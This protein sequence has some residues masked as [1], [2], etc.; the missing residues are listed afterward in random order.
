MADQ[1]LGKDECLD[2]CD[3]GVYEQGDG[4]AAEEI[5]DEGL[6]PLQRITKY[7]WAEEVYN[8]KYVATVLLEIIQMAPAEPL[9]TDLPQIMDI[10]GK[11]VH[12]AEVVV[13]IDALEHIPSLAGMA[14][15]CAQKV[16]ALANITSEYLLSMVVNNLGDNDNQVRKHAQRALFTLLEQG[17]VSK[18]QAEI[19][20]CPTILALTRKESMVTDGVTLMAKVVP[21][22]GRDVTERVF[23]DRFVELCAAMKFYV[24]KICASHVGDFCAIISRPLFEKVLFIAYAKL[25]NDEAWGV[26]KACADVAM[27][28]SCACS[29][30]LRKMV[31]APAFA[32]LLRDKCRWV[33]ISAFQTLGPFISTFAEPTI[34]SLAYN[35]M[36]ELVLV[37][38]GSEFKINNSSCTP[39]DEVKNLFYLCLDDLD[40]DSYD[41]GF[42]RK[43][44]EEGEQPL[45]PEELPQLEAPPPLDEQSNAQKTPPPPEEQLPAPK[46]LSPPLKDDRKTDPNNAWV[47]DVILKGLDDFMLTEDFD[48]D[49]MILRSNKST[50]DNKKQCDNL[51]SEISTISN[52]AS[53]DQLENVDLS[54]SEQAT[55]SSSG[56]EADRADS[57]GACAAATPEGNNDEDGLELYNS[58]NYWYVPPDMPLDPNIVAGIEIEKTASDTTDLPSAQENTDAFCKT[59]TDFE[60]NN[61]NETVVVAAAADAT[62]KADSPSDVLLDGESAEITELKEP[63]QKIV[64]QLLIDHFISMADPSI[65]Q[66]IDDNIAYHCAY[67]LPAV[68]L[69]LG[70]VNSHL[71][72]ETVGTLAANMQYKVR[73]TLASSLHELAIIWGS[74]IASNDLA[75]IFNEFIKDLDEVRI[76]VLKNLAQFLRLINPTKRSMYL[77]RLSFFLQNNQKL[78]WRYRHE[79]AEQLLKSVTMFTPSEASKHISHIAQRLL[80]DK[81]AAVR[82]MALKLVAQLLQHIN[83]EPGLSSRML[84][85]FAETFAHSKKWKLRQTFVFLSWELLVGKALPI[86]QFASDVMPHL[87]DLSWDPVANVRLVVAQTVVTHM[88][89]NEYFRDPENQ[90][91]DLLESVLRRLQTDE[92]IDVRQAAVV[93]ACQKYAY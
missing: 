48:N 54:R 73:H 56:D 38:Y 29:P 21:L 60:T 45:P 36:G 8:R 86:E 2:D 47:M 20:V 9:S 15:K 32:R 53:G 4:P 85:K 66:D 37:C 88:I 3:E 12:D 27:S 7:A 17:L 50:D 1:S 43:R 33:R 49:E 79:L 11:L 58:H 87:L 65:A 26:R 81:V 40:D 5:E 69:T 28:V 30:D 13:R 78:N 46:E 68:A 63:P 75:P 16:P 31:L 92:D 90:H 18:A 42:V 67:S 76:G 83:S 82:Q 93:D 24:R 77:P 35:N 61:L 19:Q 25:C 84:I 44:T 70:S 71:L 57:G 41:V 72:K 51:G 34:T 22:L 10:F 59:E 91:Y 14:L 23:L 55:C 80:C 62:F 74:D 39:M 6:T 89:N 64:P 52:P